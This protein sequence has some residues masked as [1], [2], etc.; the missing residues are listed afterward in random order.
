MGDDEGVSQYKSP[1]RKIA[2]ARPTAGLEL[3]SA[4]TIPPNPS[5]ADRPPAQS[6][7]RRCSAAELSGTFQTVSNS[8]ASP[9][10]TLMKNTHRQE[11]CCVN[12][13]P[14]TGPTAAVMEVKPDQVPIARPR[15]STEKLALI[16]AR[17]PGTS[18]AP[19]TPSASGNN[20]PS[21]IGRA[22]PHKA[23]RQ[24]KKSA[25]PTAKTLRRPYKV[26]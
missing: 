22:Q 5:T 21:N 12:R 10:G 23:G 17:L 16:N 19:P 4:K 20:Q 13:P 2:P 15:S 8:T 24:R 6:N 7:R 3:M 11:P 9:I 14:S 26:P 25:T 1:I 18:N